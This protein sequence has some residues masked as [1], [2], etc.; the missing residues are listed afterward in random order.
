M[1]WNPDQYLRYSDERSRPFADLVGRVGATAPRRVVDLGCG[2]GNLMALLTERWPHAEIDG[3]DSSPQ[4]IEQA[5]RLST[6]RVHFRV[7]D[8]ATWSVPPDADVVTTNAALQWVPEHRDLLR[9]WA[10]QLPA[11]GWLAMQVPGNFGAPSHRLMRELA[12]SPRWA[13]QLGGTLRLH[14]S[15]AE[16]EEYAELLLAAGLE[17]DVWETTYLHL[18][19]G[20]DPVLEWLRGTGLRPVLAA[21]N[22]A[23]A[24]E[25]EAE[26]GA[27][28][29]AAY[30]ATEYG[31][32]LPFRR[33]FAVAHRPAP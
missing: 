26:F 6:T 13:G 25:F 18:L 14:D 8:I 21:L 16:P 11:D 29:R 27:T 4:M 20:P 7:D 1:Q 23:D 5:S 19:P 24:A 12:E 9:A 3:I 31:T 15:V 33:I 17:V 28:L 30:P 22:A 2:A 10:G 32:V